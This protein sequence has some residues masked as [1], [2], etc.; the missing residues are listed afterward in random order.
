MLSIC[1]LNKA[2]GTFTLGVPRLFQA[3]NPADQHNA[4]IMKGT[5]I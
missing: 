2:E 4:E 5:S 3:L 1:Q